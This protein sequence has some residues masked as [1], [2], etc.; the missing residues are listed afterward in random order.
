MRVS[1]CVCECLCVCVF[2]CVCVRVYSQ[3]FLKYVVMKVLKTVRF[4]KN[5]FLDFLRNF[6]KSFVLRIFCQ[7]KFCE[8]VTFWKKFQKIFL[9]MCRKYVPVLTR[10]AGKACQ[11]QYLWPGNTKGGSITVPLTSY[12]TGLD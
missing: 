1:V 12:L 4:R 6:A 9:K 11:G 5:F 10:K 3:N 7:L 2:V 8:K